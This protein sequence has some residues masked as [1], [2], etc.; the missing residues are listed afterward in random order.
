[1]TDVKATVVIDAYNAINLMKFFRDNPKWD[2][3]TRREKLCSI[4]VIMAGQTGKRFIV[5][6]DGYC[7]GEKH[8]GLGADVSVVF[9]GGKIA[10][11]IIERMSFSDNARHMTV[12]TCD[13]QVAT[14]CRNRGARVVSVQEFEKQYQLLNEKIC[15]SMIS[16]KGGRTDESRDTFADSIDSSTLKRLNRMAEA[17]RL[18]QKKE[19]ERLAASEKAGLV[20]K[21][22]REEAEMFLDEMGDDVRKIKNKFADFDEKDEKPSKKSP[23]SGGGKTAGPSVKVSKDAKTA[24]GVP[25]VKDEKRVTPA[26][27]FDW[28][29]H[30]DESF[31][32]SGPKKK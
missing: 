8:S 28:T 20:K 4:A 22:E 18:E 24:R 29:K 5:V 7:S 17:R 1:M 2:L 16:E 14:I 11:T 19:I 32:K 3:R 26:E 9:S 25:V 6:F 12:V 15:A 23:N 13:N 30:I 10:D 21:T 27:P 31:S